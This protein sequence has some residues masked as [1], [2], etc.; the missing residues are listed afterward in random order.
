MW[1]GGGLTFLG[2]GSLFFVCSE[3][4]RKAKV[5]LAGGV[6]E[7]EVPGLQLFVGFSHHPDGV[8]HSVSSHGLFAG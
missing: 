5:E 7:S 4:S 8:S 1:M 2:L 6:V 3:L